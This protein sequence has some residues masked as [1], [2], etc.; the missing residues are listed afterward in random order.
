[1]LLGALC[2]SH[3]RLKAKAAR[4]LYILAGDVVIFLIKEKRNYLSRFF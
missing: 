1:M 3:K 4:H 2:R